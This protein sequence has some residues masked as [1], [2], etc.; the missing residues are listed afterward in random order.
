M[1]NIFNQDFREFLHALNNQKV[2]YLLVGGY[3]VIL[4]GYPRTTGDMDIWVNRNAANYQRLKNA[5][6]QFCMPMFDMTE[7]RFLHHP[8]I[9]VFRFGRK[10]V[11]IDIMTKMGDLNFEECYNM[12]AVFTD[13]DLTIKVVHYN[14]LIAAKKAAGRHKDLGDIEYLEN[15]DE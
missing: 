3:A 8:E 14:H 2:E 10:P 9:D 12:A 5:F 11:A 4:H 15:G 6:A 13:D 7:E 1:G